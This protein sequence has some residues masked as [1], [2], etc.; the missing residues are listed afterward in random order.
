MAELRIGRLYIR[1]KMIFRSPIQRGR[2]LRFEANSSGGGSG[3]DDS[4][5]GERDGA[6]ERR[7]QTAQREQHI[8]YRQDLSLHQG[9]LVE[10]QG[11]AANAAWRPRSSW[12]SR[13]VIR[14]TN[15]AKSRRE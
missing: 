11:P 10:F 2:R 12:V 1:P 5:L 15:P 6:G 4:D 8:K 13:F 9:F 14:T 3:R 7:L